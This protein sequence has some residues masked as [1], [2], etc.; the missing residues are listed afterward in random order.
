MTTAF[1]SLRKII[2]CKICAYPAGCQK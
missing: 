2:S 1:A